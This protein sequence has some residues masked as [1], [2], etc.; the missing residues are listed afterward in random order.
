MNNAFHIC[1]HDQLL[2][3]GS[4][5][6]IMEVSPCPATE[7]SGHRHEYNNNG[8]VSC[9]YIASNCAAGT[10]KGRAGAHGY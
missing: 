1:K 6:D 9:A 10:E 3:A 2:Q 5:P 7:Y 8:N 4:I